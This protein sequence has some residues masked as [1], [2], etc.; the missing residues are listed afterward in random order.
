LGDA[1]LPDL[2]S[3]GHVVTEPTG[4]NSTR[5]EFGSPLSHAREPSAQV[6][7]GEAAVLPTRALSSPSPLDRA[8]I[9]S[10]SPYLSR[11]SPDRG[12]DL[13]GSR[14]IIDS[15]QSTPSLP[16]DPRDSTII[17]PRTLG[18]SRS[19]YVDYDQMKYRFQIPDGQRP[20]YKL[21]VQLP[22]P[23]VVAL[24][25]SGMVPPSPYWRG[26]LARAAGLRSPGASPGA[27]SSLPGGEAICQNILDTYRSINADIEVNNLEIRQLDKEVRFLRSLHTKNSELEA[28]ETKKQSLLD[29]RA[30]LLGSVQQIAKPRN[31]GSAASPR[32]T[33]PSICTSSHSSRSRPHGNRRSLKAGTFDNGA[34]S[35]AEGSG[36]SPATGA[37]VVVPPAVK[38]LERPVEANKCPTPWM[39]S[40][41]QDFR[42]TLPSAPH[43][44][45]ASLPPPTTV[46]CGSVQPPS[47][48][49]AAPL[50]PVLNNTSLA[51]PQALAQAAPQPPQPVVTYRA[52]KTTT[53][54]S[55]F[56]YP[57]GLAA[58]GIGSSTS[59]AVLPQSRVTYSRAGGS[60]VV[61]HG[62]AL[63]QPSPQ[64]QPRCEYAKPIPVWGAGN[65]QRWFNALGA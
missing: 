65:T 59:R 40:P 2:A 43:P 16:Y 12:L 60:T 64:V 13:D 14:V 33:S 15:T 34:L 10:D 31:L 32:A 54:R 44:R 18:V 21:V 52:T 8:H 37:S 51:R 24:D 6:D 30:M 57:S 39:R 49:S 50:G 38:P 9:L 17:V 25:W 7:C 36:I 41:A 19:A 42:Q 55:T 45:R 61:P 27:A 26:D 58:A 4:S 11:S 53:P 20:G 23:E 28:T 62:A 56:G 3:P 5:L 63:R 22:G 46:W 47:R 29:E 1:A 48:S 35:S